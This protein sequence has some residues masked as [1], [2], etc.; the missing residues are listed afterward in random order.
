M[1]QNITASWRRSGVDADRAAMGA[2]GSDFGAVAILTARL[3]LHLG[4]NLALGAPIAP[5]SGHVRDSAD[6]HSAQNLAAVAAGALQL[7]HS[8]SGPHTRRA[9]GR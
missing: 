5:Q 2:A 6:S 8:T 4:Q 3:P 1:S 7:G 9:F